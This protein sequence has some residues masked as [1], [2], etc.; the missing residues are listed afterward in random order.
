M[1]MAYR[2]FENTHALSNSVKIIFWKLKKRIRNHF[3]DK[4]QI[5]LKTL[6]NSMHM[7]ILFRYCPFLDQTFPNKRL[8]F[9]KML[10]LAD[11]FLQTASHS[12]RHTFNQRFI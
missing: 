2:A 11:F 5:L 8:Q 12:K 4:A 7:S 10:E 1:K 3:F 6:F 9:A